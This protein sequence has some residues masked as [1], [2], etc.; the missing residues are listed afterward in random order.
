VDNSVSIDLLLMLQAVSEQIKVLL[1][2]IWVYSSCIV[3]T[4]CCHK[5]CRIKVR[6][7]VYIVAYS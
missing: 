2:C 4:H 5:R 3:A 6:P 1:P 7:S